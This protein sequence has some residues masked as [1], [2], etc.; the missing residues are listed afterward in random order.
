MISDDEDEAMSNTTPS[1]I[2][3]TPAQDTMKKKIAKLRMELDLTERRKGSLVADGT[4][5]D[6]ARNLRR[7]IDICERKLKL[8]EKQRVYSITHRKNKKQKIIEL[9]LKNPD[10]A[11]SL[12]PHVGPGRPRWPWTP[13]FRRR[14]V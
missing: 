4:E 1:N 7:E 13:T 6:K 10:A 12:T 3:P 11:K 8:K 9:C 5:F 14:T 2:R